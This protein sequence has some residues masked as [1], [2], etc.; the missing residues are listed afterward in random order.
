MLASHSSGA[1][2]LT[3][4]LPNSSPQSSPDSTG[5]HSAPIK[6]SH[7][8]ADL[9]PRQTMASKASS[10]RF[11]TPVQGDTHEDVIGKLQAIMQDYLDFE[12]LQ[13]IQTLEKHVRYALNLRSG[14][15]L[16]LFAFSNLL[17]TPTK[18]DTT[19]ARSS[20]NFTKKLSIEDL[21][22][23]LSSL[24]KDAMRLDESSFYIL[25]NLNDEICIFKNKTKTYSLRPT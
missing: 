5:E 18:G 8:H 10:N 6:N 3:C 17:S 13:M 12:K 22:K 19:A 24:C 9:K 16:N 14:Q 23:K 11:E 20:Q 21:I 2:R 25:K 15:H 4:A 7:S 1:S